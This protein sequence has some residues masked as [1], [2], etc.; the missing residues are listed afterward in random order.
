M[1][2]VQLKLL[3]FAHAHDQLGFREQLVEYMPSETPRMLLGRLAPDV[4]CDTMRV[5]VD[6]EYRGWDEPLGEAREL[7]LI[8]PV[9]GG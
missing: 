6:Y 3:A 5:A 9:S 7:A 8:P 1:H 2:A 4:Q